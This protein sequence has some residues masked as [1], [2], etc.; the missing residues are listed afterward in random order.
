MS[1][2]NSISK[3]GIMQSLKRKEQKTSKIETL[4]EMRRMK[5]EDERER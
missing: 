4:I 5:Q 3:F 1:L 2:K